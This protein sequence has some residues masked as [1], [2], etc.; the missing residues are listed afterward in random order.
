MQGPALESQQ[1]QAMLEAW[2]RMAGKLRFG[3]GPGG[4]D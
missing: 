3:K 1:P 2:G 4:A